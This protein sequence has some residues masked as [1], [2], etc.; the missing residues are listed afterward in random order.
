MAELPRQG[1]QVPRR[2]KPSRLRHEVRTESTDD[3]RDR[4]KPAPQ[5]PDSDAIVPETQPNQDG[6]YVRNDFTPEREPDLSDLPTSP[7]TAELL[8]RTAVTKKADTH[9]SSW[10]PF[11]FSTRTKETPGVNNISGPA[12]VP[13]FA[14]TRSQ[15]S[16]VPKKASPNDETFTARFVPNTEST[17]PGVHKQVVHASQ[18]ASV[19][20]E[21]AYVSP[22]I[23]PRNDDRHKPNPATDQE[24]LLFQQPAAKESQDEPAYPLPTQAD[25]PSKIP[26]SAQPDARPTPGTSKVRVVKKSKKGRKGQLSQQREGQR[27][28][29]SNVLARHAQQAMTTGKPVAETFNNPLATDDTTVHAY[30][31]HTVQASAPINNPDG[32][33]YI[34]ESPL[35]KEHE[36]VAHVEESCNT[37]QTIPDTTFQDFPD[38]SA[39]REFPTS[40]M[41][42]TSTLPPKVDDTQREQQ[43]LADV[44]DQD[45]GLTSAEERT[46]LPAQDSGLHIP[47]NHESV[48]I[49][50]QSNQLQQP[51]VSASSQQSA[52]LP[53]D[54]EAVLHRISHQ[55]AFHRVAKPR[56]KLRASG[57]VPNSPQEQVI[58]SGLDQAIESVRVAMLA[59]K[60]RAKHESMIIAKQREVEIAGLQGTINDHVQTIAE[61][62]E[63]IRSLKEAFSQL[64][65]KAKTNQKFVHGLQQDYEKLQKSATSFQKQSQRTLTEK[66]TE[67]EDEKKTLYREFE[68]AID[69]LAA[70]QRKMK[71][72]LEDV[73]KRFIMSES[74]RGYLIENLGKRD[75]ELGEERRKRED[76]EKQLLSSV[77]SIPGKIVDASDTL[78]K[79]LASLQTSFEQAS[80]HDDRKNPIEE[81][82]DAL[83]TLQMSPALT[84]KDIEKMEGTLRL[85]HER[86]LHSLDSGLDTLSETLRSEPTPD[87]ELRTFIGERLNSLQE[88]MLRYDE[89]TTENRKTQELN[90]SLKVKLEEQQQHS[91][92]LNEQIKELQQSEVNLRAQ[93]DQLERDLNGLRVSPPVPHVDVAKLEQEAVDL[94][95]RLKKVE[96]DLEAANNKVETIEQER[97]TYK[98]H[99]EDVKTQLQEQQQ[100]HR[101]EDDVIIREEIVKDCESGFI[102]K[103]RSLKSEIDRLTT[104]RDE[105]ENAYQE[106]SINWNAANTQINELEDKIRT[107]ET[108][109][110]ETTNIQE[111]L[112]QTTEELHTKGR[113][114]AELSR[115]CEENVEKISELQGLLDK[116]QA[117]AVEQRTTMQ[118]M[119]EEADTTLGKVQ[120]DASNTLQLLHIQISK[121]QEEKKDVSSKVQQARTNE[122]KLRQDLAEL[123]AAKEANE[124]RCQKDADE[125][126]QK[127]NEQHRT[128]IDDWNRRL[129][130]KDAALEKAEADLRLAADQFKVKLAADREKAESNMQ[131]LERQYQDVIK[132]EREKVRR[133]QQDD[134]QVQGGK[135]VLENPRDA[136]QIAKPRKKL[137][138]QN[139]SVLDGLRGHHF[140]KPSWALDAEFSQT[141]LD[142][143]DLFATQHGTY[144]TLNNAD[145]I[146]HEAGTATETQDIGSASISQDMFNMFRPSQQDVNRQV[147]S[148]LNLSSIS[149]DDLAALDETQP[150]SGAM[151][152]GYVRDSSNH[153]STH[154]NAKA[155]PAVDTI[156]V[157]GSH[158]SRSSGR[159]RSQAN[160]A[161]RMMPPPGNGFRYS[162]SGTGIHTGEREGSTRQTLY[163]KSLEM[164]GGSSTHASDPRD[165][166]RPSSQQTNNQ[167]DPRRSAQPGSQHGVTHPTKQGYTEKRKSSSDLAEKESASKKQRTRSQ[168]RPLNSSTDLPGKSP[169]ASGKSASTSRPKAQKT[170][171]Y[172]QASAS[173][174]S[175]SKTPVA[176][177][178]VRGR[179]T[180][181]APSSSGAYSPRGQPSSQISTGGPTRRSSTR[182]TRSQSKDARYEI[183]SN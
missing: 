173:T 76:M 142:D 88:A 26:P 32:H 87:T 43:P 97:D 116:S 128:V 65:D 170:L 124:S 44:L 100:K 95:L 162:Q 4:K 163:G 94:R 62:D 93:S 136:V 113:G 12:D 5:E 141:Q 159:P 58:S 34:E 182:L 125:E 138:R 18:D 48:A 35:M 15:P 73:Y 24:V 51:E 45:R 64:T 183:V 42:V 70:T 150:A 143:D 10:V 101:V 172:G 84:T 158:S 22:P 165:Q 104:E 69:R 140:E 119:R 107:L 131:K 17:M 153:A 27:P 92:Q 126:R 137:Q 41:F 55:D 50:T 83:R 90:V 21:P 123:R 147:S 122:G 86:Q 36:C 20:V 30:Q 174:S 168:S 181:Q 37:T 71:S 75:A 112:R 54:S 1:K 33:T 98:S 145:S 6:Y 121:L 79:K 139:H 155:T 61:R 103:E 118:T 132:A 171:L 179:V 130:E 108:K 166:T 13:A 74:K 25:T 60:F 111:Q 133:N 148:S 160:T 77:Q 40:S 106:V 78:A 14:F 96:S 114:H 2:Q 68:T 135:S 154:A 102:E 63:S 99:S 19:A 127:L 178:R 82:L 52:P 80:A 59:D 129:T 28:P 110:L 67:L 7:G 89:A 175:R 11:A 151:L 176:S 115:R 167:Y 3:E 66:I 117:Q 39:Q 169:Y 120:Q 146:E 56:R 38:S 144:E 109:A 157:A 72:T 29:R 177:S 149:L 134:S 47:D 49:A 161:S 180:R 53:K 16:Q 23:F 31:P 85:V 91:Y 46:P 57:P 152:R 105:K 9:T 8:Q 164:L 156:S 81:C